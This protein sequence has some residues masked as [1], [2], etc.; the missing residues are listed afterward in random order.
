[1]LISPKEIYFMAN[2]IKK[3]NN[4]NDKYHIHVGQKLNIAANREYYK[5]TQGMG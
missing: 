5:L 3:A 4:L 1:M 2:L